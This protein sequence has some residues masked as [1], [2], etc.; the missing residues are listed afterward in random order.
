MEDPLDIREFQKVYTNLSLLISL[1]L[2][3]E[4]VLLFQSHRARAIDPKKVEESE[5]LKVWIISLSPTARWTS[6]LYSKFLSGSNKHR[7]TKTQ[8]AGIMHS[9]FQV[10]LLSILVMARVKEY[11]LVLSY[12]NSK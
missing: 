4:Q 11:W 1:L 7:K 3:K 12:I 10:A 5:T 8:T 6:S 2:S 9:V